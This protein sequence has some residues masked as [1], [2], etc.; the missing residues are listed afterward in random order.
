VTSLPSF[1]ERFLG[2]GKAENLD[3][4]PF[5]K[6]EENQSLWTNSRYGKLQFMRCPG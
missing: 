6:G 1:E 3:R 4:I 5:S 2:L